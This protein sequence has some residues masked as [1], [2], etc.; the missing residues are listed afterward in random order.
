MISDQDLVYLAGNSVYFPDKKSVKTTNNIKYEVFE[1][2][3]ENPQ[4]AV[5]KN[6]ETGE[7]VLSF[8]GTNINE[9]E[10]LAAD[11]QLGGEGV[12][13]LHKRALEIYKRVNQ[14]YPISAVCGNSLGGSL[15]NYVSVNTGVR[16]VTINPAVLPNDQETLNK[17]ND[18]I[19]NYIA[20]G[21]PLDILQK[22]V[23]IKNKQMPGKTTSFHYGYMLANRQAFLA[24]HVGYNVDENG[25]SRIK[26]G[27]GKV[28]ILVD[29]TKNI[30]INPYTNKPYGET[31]SDFE[32]TINSE[33]LEILKNEIIQMKNECI[34]SKKY[35]DQ[36][37]QIAD[38]YERNFE[39]RKDELTAF[40]KDLIYN[41]I[42][43]Y[44]LITLET[45]IKSIN[46]L[47]FDNIINVLY[48]IQ[49]TELVEFFTPNIIN[50][51]RDIKCVVRGLDQ[52]KPLLLEFILKFVNQLMFDTTT[53][54]YDEFVKRVCLATK[55][56]NQNANLLNDK[57]Q[58]LENQV[59]T[60]HNSWLELDEA[61]ATGIK[62]NANVTPNYPQIEETNKV[63][64][65]ELNN[66]I[67]NV[68][69][70]Y[71]KFIDKKYNR[72]VN[73]ILV[74]EIKRV[75]K[76]ILNSANDFLSNDEV[77]ITLN[78]LEQVRDQSE[79]ANRF[80]E[81][82]TEISNFIYQYENGINLVI[83][84]LSKLDDVLY[85][86]GPYIKTIIFSNKTYDEIIMYY[87]AANNSYLSNEQMLNELILC[88]DQNEN[89]TIRTIKDNMVDIKTF[90]NSLSVQVDQTV[91]T[92]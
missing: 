70:N 59:T 6:K 92:N 8:Q 34:E 29:A 44:F 41:K 86:F 81:I 12:P 74:L 87:M 37:V 11:L 52:L 27:E 90:L 63:P 79:V 68:I 46:N 65:N 28:D 55:T 42:S 4:C 58:V 40:I 16:S 71:E 25:V 38:E 13:N 32:I 39:A 75:A 18:N 30:V 19:R 60:V 10:D 3:E 89:K 14:K 91:I 80:V 5:F 1:Y 78:N 45:Q 35:V 62:T 36:V 33:N 53:G 20:T 17:N 76:N 82:L 50:I 7:F 23:D 15:A 83:D 64:F 84:K 26:M 48:S 67:L 72:L 9:M 22:S 77:R 56:I 66:E 21:D 88:I 49:N 85:E 54:R 61:I 43:A 51:I 57:L 47:P 24:S 73:S 31:G 69:N 2:Y